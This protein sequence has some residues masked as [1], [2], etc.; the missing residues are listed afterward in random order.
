MCLD[1][2]VQQRQTKKKLCPK[3]FIVKIKQ[4]GYGKM[5]DKK[6]PYTYHT[7]EK[8]RYQ[9]AKSQPQMPQENC[10][11]VWAGKISGTTHPVSM[12]FPR[13][14]LNH[15]EKQGTELHGPLI[16]LTTA[17]LTFFN[18]ATSPVWACFKIH[19]KHF[20]LLGKNNVGLL[21][22]SCWGF[23]GILCIVHCRGSVMLGC[24]AISNI[25]VHSYMSL[26]FLGA[27][28]LDPVHTDI[29]GMY[30]R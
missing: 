4:A 8:L 19:W 9:N 14:L 21:L 5:W 3:E 23:I 11:K 25:D 20:A 24:A 17:V 6:H 18:L 22:I 12:L 2:K 7:I 29:R 28:R 15:C 10:G 30:D 1:V 13:H 16:W 27:L 26:Q